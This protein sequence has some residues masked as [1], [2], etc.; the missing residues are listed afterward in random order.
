MAGIKITELPSIGTL[1]TTDLTYVVDVST[2]TSKSATIDNILNLVQRIQSGDAFGGTL[3]RLSVEFGTDLI[4]VSG[5]SGSYSG[6]QYEADYSVNYAQS[7]LITR[8]DAPRIFVQNDTPTNT[9][10]KADKIGDVYFDTTALVWYIANGTGIPDWVIMGNSYSGTY[11]PT[12]SPNGA[13]PTPTPLNAHYSVVGNLV[14]VKIFMEGDF[15][16]HNNTNDF[17]LPIQPIASFSTGFEIIGSVTPTS[18]VDHFQTAS[19]S[20]TIGGYNGKFSIVCDSSTT[21]TIRYLLD[22]SYFIQ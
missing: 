15:P 2:D 17:D 14:N 19:V 8:G 6:I 18:F 11:T 16:S 9:N 13:Q 4:L 1:E 10:T 5:Q 12:I 22:F 3:N 20:S 7:S 21:G